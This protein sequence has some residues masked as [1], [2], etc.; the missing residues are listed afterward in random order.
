MI[1]TL[2]TQNDYC[3]RI[4]S[5][6]IPNVLLEISLHLSDLIEVRSRNGTRQIISQAN[7]FN[8]R[9]RGIIVQA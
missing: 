4:I 8:L 5:G 3:S 7:D 1:A 2:I 9:H 6:W